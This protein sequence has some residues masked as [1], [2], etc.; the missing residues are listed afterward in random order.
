MSDGIAATRRPQG[1][2]SAE[3]FAPASSLLVHDIKN[4][5]FRLGALLQNLEKH[6]DDPLFKKSVVEVLG[7]TVDKMDRM[8]RRCRDRRDGV[9][10]KFP[11]DL[12]EVLDRV[13]GS[14]PQEKRSG[15]GIL[16][17][18]RYGRIPKIWGDPD[19]LGEALV[20]IIQN[21]LEA[22]E[23]E[24]GTVI[25]ETRA[26]KSRTGKRRVI[27]RI[28][29]TG[30]GMDA[31]FVRKCLF[32]PFCTTKPGGLGMGLYACKKIIALHEGSIRVS[33]RLGRGTT[34]RISFNAA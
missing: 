18:A 33:S 12:N 8:V 19:F 22:I 29:D 14:I 11:I 2:K 26:T 28:S 1:R 10:I 7:D 16:T 6:Y 25:I 24:T 21:A 27:V 32:T 20:I 31:E 4:L 5:S 30:C 23:D 34:F 9:I 3:T 17:E 13:V 15:Q